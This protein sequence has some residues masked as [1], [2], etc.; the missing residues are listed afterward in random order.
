MLS[1]AD[2]WGELV[3]YNCTG[4]MVNR[5]QQ[6]MAGLAA[7]QVMEAV[8]E[9]WEVMSVG[10][11][12]KSSRGGN[13]RLVTGWRSLYQIP[14]RW[15]Q[16]VEPCDPVLWIDELTSIAFESG[17]GS[18]TPMISGQTRN[19]RYS[20]NAEKAFKIFKSELIRTNMAYGDHDQVLY[21]MAHCTLSRIV[22]Y[23]AGIKYS[24][25]HIV[26]S[27]AVFLSTLFFTCATCLWCAGGTLKARGHAPA[28]GSL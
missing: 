5:R 23:C 19:I 27:C 28:R 1:L 2:K 25:L 12:L 26:F 9:T 18:V 7:M 22:L 24:F 16:I 20:M 3:Q 11:G 4:F 21:H 10:K 6:R 8:R 14:V 13:D 17:F 15:R